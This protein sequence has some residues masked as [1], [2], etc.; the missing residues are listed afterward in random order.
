MA[1]CKAHAAS[2]PQGLSAA[3]IAAIALATVL[4]AGLVA[5]LTAML[6]WRRL[7]RGGPGLALGKG[8]TLVGSS[9]YVKQIGLA[10]PGEASTV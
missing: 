6:A 5:G 4:V 1:A 8:D 10:A 2:R 3:A 7:S 9:T